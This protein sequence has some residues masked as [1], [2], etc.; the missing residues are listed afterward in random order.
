MYLTYC[1]IL[2]IAYVVGKLSWYTQSPNQDHWTVV[3]KVLKYLRG[4]IYYGLCYNRFMSVLEGFNDANYI[5]NSD[6]MKSTNEYVFTL[7]RGAIS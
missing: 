3:G 6:E 5:S 1:T 7:G 4:T 2:D